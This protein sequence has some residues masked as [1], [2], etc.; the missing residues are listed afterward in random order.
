MPYVAWA[1]RRRGVFGVGH[2][3]PAAATLVSLMALWTYTILPL[4]DP[5][6]L[7]RSDGGV[8]PQFIPLGSLRE[9]DLAANGWRDPMIVQ[10]VMNVALFVPAGL[11]RSRTWCCRCR[12]GE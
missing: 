1:Y 9:V 6:L 2:A 3:V 10:M 4:P 11:G 8:A 7:D 5:A 12:P